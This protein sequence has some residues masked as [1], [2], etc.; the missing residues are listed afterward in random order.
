MNIN[1]V[2]AISSPK[3]VKKKKFFTRNNIIL[4]LM[5]LP[6]LIS[7]I[8]F[9]HFDTNLS[10]QLRYVMP[11]ILTVVV[12]LLMVSNIKFDNLPRPTKRSFQERPFVFVI[13][14]VAFIAILLSKGYLIFPFMIFYIVASSLRHFINWIKLSSIPIDEFDE[15]IEDE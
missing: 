2:T 9:H 8:I 15:N 13:F 4:Y 14:T 10:E 12:P 1:N 6:V 11:Y 3:K 7:Y 5:L